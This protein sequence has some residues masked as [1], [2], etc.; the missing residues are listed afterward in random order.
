[1]MPSALPGGFQSL[2]PFV[3]YWSGETTQMRW[4]RRSAATME[5]IQSFYDAMLHH[6]D[7]ALALLQQRPLSELD[8]PEAT[9]L[10]LLLSLASCAIA[11]ELHGQPRAPYSPYP[12]GIRV[13]KGSAPYG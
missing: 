9:L 1:M 10:R 12:H 3:P 13:L 6:A 4:D 8:E 2:D 5:E 7:A 11:I